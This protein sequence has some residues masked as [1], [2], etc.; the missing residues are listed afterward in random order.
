MSTGI[1]QLPWEQPG[2]LAQVT[3]WIHSRLAEHGRRANAPVEVVHRRAWSA[4]AR[5]PTS[6]GPVYFKAAAPSV[7]FQAPLAEALAHWRPDCMLPILA[8]DAERGWLLSPGAGV[9]L[10][11]LIASPEYFTHWH[12][13]LPLYV[14]VQRESVPR[15][16][17]LL[18]A[19]VDVVDL[20]AKD[21]DEISW[22]GP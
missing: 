20:A 14:G 8:V 18:A 3:S 15:L 13:L 21:R 6:G 7:R 9:T 16:P 1:I 17:A 12:A 10:R 22:R 19:H 2:W 4:F 5:V 11:S